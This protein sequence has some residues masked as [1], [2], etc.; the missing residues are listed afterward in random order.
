MKTFNNFNISQKFKNSVIAIGNFDGV[1]TGHQ[2]TLRDAKKQAVKKKISLGVLTFEPIPIMFFK[3]K[4]KN[5]R[6][7]SLEQKKEFLKKQRVDFIIIKK[8]DKKFSNI[9]YLNFIKDIL[10]KKIK[11]RYLYVSK[12]FRFGKNREGDIRKLKFFER[13][14]QFKTIVTKIF[15]IN[16]KIISSTKIRK[17][18]TTGH[19]QKANNFLGRNWS[20]RSKVIRGFQRGRKIGFP[21]CNLKLLNYVIPKSGVYSVRVK[22][23]SFYKKGIANVGYRPTFNGKNL[24]LE[25]NIFGINK[26]LYNKVLNIDFIKFIRPEKKFKDLEE[27]K[28]QISTD[29]S[30][31]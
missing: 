28:K 17:L 12:N 21:T 24:L 25:V 19:I 29:I 26:Y 10:F 23:K 18:I 1:H 20:V 13:K 6:I 3:K 5:H 27:L 15:K 2:K 31:V 4:I 11:C 7:N 9:D 8:F 16:K 22:T 14:F 30:K